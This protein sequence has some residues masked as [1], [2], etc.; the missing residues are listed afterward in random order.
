M[1]A[2]DSHSLIGLYGGSFDPVHEGHI[3]TA[4]ELSQRLPFQEIRLIPAALSP[5]KSASTDARHRVKL[6]ELAIAPYPT[7]S[8]DTRELHREGPSY[9]IDTLRDIRAEH[10]PE[11]R[12]VFIIGMDSLINL[13]K[14]RDWQ[15]LTQLAH[16][17][18][19]SRPGFSPDFS[20]EL[21]SWLKSV[22]TSDA[23][24]LQSRPFG[25]LL[26][27]NTQP[28]PIASSDI[29]SHIA[30]RRPASTFLNPRVWDYIEEH[31]LY[32]ERS[33]PNESA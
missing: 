20:P 31:G 29:R 7:L 12:L 5:L 13:P 19:A 10:G 21:A 11:A 3:Q 32:S 8:I 17:V 33:T 28:W 27:L 26:M 18:V 15:E 22:Q 6:L 2:T 23:T 9:T 30:A 24:L 4:V 25:A 1:S 14:W 16:I